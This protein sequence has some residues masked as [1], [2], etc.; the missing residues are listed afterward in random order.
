[1]GRYG[2]SYGDRRD[3]YKRPDA[4]NNQSYNSQ[5]AES[6]M[7]YCFC[8]APSGEALSSEKIIT[9]PPNLKTLQSCVDG[10][11][12]KLHGVAKT[13]W[14]SS[15]ASASPQRPRALTLAE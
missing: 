10:P 2:R 9:N 7:V 14:P 1:M 5:R 13:T 12:E 6:D 4:E 3:T 11:F 15:S 8:Y